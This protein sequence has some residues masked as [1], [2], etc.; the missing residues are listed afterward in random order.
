MSPA[1]DPDDHPHLER[2]AVKALERIA[3]AL[4]EVVKVMPALA[5]AGRNAPYGEERR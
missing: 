4:E 5:A 2:R 1:E 3:D